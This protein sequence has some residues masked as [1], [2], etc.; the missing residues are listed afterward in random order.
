MIATHARGPHDPE[1]EVKSAEAGRV[2]SII[3]RPMPGGGW[4]ATHEDISERRKAERERAAMQEQQ[5]R[6]SAI[7]Q[8][9]VTFRQRVE[10]HLRSVA[11]G[12]H[13][14][15]LDRRRAVRKLRPDLDKAPKA[16]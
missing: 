12:A 10:E 11:D 7:E 3:N 5:Q 9:I 13:G 2:I 4:V 6:R 1:H 8:A 14:H 15:A 16:R